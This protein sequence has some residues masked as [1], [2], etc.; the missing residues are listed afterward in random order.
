MSSE[1]GTKSMKDLVA[2]LANLK[3][4]IDDYIN[5]VNAKIEGL[6]KAKCAAESSLEKKQ[7]TNA[8][9]KIK[10]QELDSTSEQIKKVL[11]E[12]EEKRATAIGD[13]IEL[14]KKL[15]EKINTNTNLRV[16]SIDIDSKKTKMSELVGDI[17]THKN[18]V[19]KLKGVL[20]ELTNENDS[21]SAKIKSLEN[22]LTA[23][24]KQTPGNIANTNKIVEDSKKQEITDLQKKRD[25]IQTQ[26]SETNT[27]LTEHTAYL[28]KS[29]IELQTENTKLNELL[30]KQLNELLEKLNKENKDASTTNEVES[31]LN[32]DYLKSLSEITKIIAEK[33]HHIG[34]V[35]NEIETNADKLNE[36]TKQTN[37]LKN[38]SDDCESKMKELNETITRL[39]ENIISLTNSVNSNTALISPASSDVAL[40]INLNRNGGN[41][42][43]RR[44]TK[45]TI[46]GGRKC[47]PSKPSKLYK[48]TKKHV[49]NNRSTKRKNRRYKKLTYKR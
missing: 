25:K 3:K 47:K 19:S 4:N 44:T 27:L 26:I 31:K 33:I 8:E 20:L 35:S 22:D 43:F 42:T 45:S 18:K 5:V 14:I 48:K 15:F 2:S 16:E 30:E 28:N 38:E 13:V 7:E 34:V 9:T 17:E 24:T 49:P 40:E 46:K 32:I 21:L 1:T 37:T 41:N 29:I 23:S 12:Q 39:N 6:K 11:K 10:I 36:I